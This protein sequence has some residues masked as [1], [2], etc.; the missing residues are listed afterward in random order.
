M[1]KGVKFPYFNMQQMN[2]DWL[3]ARVA[4]YPEVVDAP[5]LSADNNQS[6]YAVIDSMNDNTSVGLS[7][8]VCG[9]A[10]DEEVKRCC[11]VLWKMDFNN[12]YG[13][14]LSTSDNLRGK[15]CAKINGNWM[16]YA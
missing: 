15:R 10:D 7:F 14:I 12:I 1:I 13:I 2:L 16:M 5:P 6:V 9:D 8:L 3:L 4:H 11:I